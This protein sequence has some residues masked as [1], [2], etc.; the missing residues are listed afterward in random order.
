MNT[1]TSDGASG[2]GS[3]QNPQTTTVTQSPT[4]NYRR[5]C[6]RGIAALLQDSTNIQGSGKRKARLKANA[7]I[8]KQS[9]RHAPR[10]KPLAGFKARVRNSALSDNSDRTTLRGLS[11]HDNTAIIDGTAYLQAYIQ[12]N[13]AYEIQKASAISIMATAMTVWGCCITEAA[14]RAAD[15]TGFHPKT[16]QDWASAFFVSSS[17]LSSEDMTDEHITED[18]SSDRGHRD[19]HSGTLLHSEEFQL[20]ARTFVRSN[21]CKKG[22][23]NL[24]SEMFVEWIDSTYG[25]RIHKVTARRWLS[26]LGFSR[27][28]HQKGVY[29]DGHDRDD[30]VLYRNNFL[31]KLSEL[32][33]T[34]LIYDGAT[35]QLDEGE[36]ALIRVVHDESTYY[37]NSDQTFFWADDE[38]NVLRQKS[39]G[40]A[41]MV[42]DFVDEVG[43]FI[44]DGEESARLLLETNKDGYFNNELLI[45]QVEKTIDIFQRIHPDC[46]GIFLFD[47]AP[48]HR[49]VADDALNGDKMNVGPGGKQPKMRD[50]VWEGHVQKMVDRNGIPKGMKAIL[51]ER[52]VDTVGMKGTDMRK[53]IKSYPDFQQQ[54]TILEDHVERRGH[55][56][57]FYPKFHCE[58]SP[59]ERVWCQSKQY[60]RAHVDGTITRLR[61]IVPEGLD[62]VTVDQIKKYFRT[63]RDYERAYR[64]GVTG[65]EV[66]ERVKVFKSHRRITTCDL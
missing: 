23:P 2:T 64:E 20:A 22:Q 25:K 9:A 62:S 21:T 10:G 37:A 28:H 32:D 58:L 7:A 3:S 12:R 52:G 55:I 35:P 39:L 33:K 51:E 60:T 54:K 40:A 1:S 44:C 15:C 19:T 30:V 16:V 11:T 26:A 57:L 49:K 42:S 4:R 59:I 6:K 36:K 27:V 45:K 8:C 13:A 50:T 56:C 17:A 14:S 29:F 47:N 5:G 66:E 31:T 46:R 24:T 61:A 65:R 41:I 63:C 48:S 53:L 18:L 43:G 38:T 34:S